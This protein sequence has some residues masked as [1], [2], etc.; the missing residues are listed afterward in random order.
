MFMFQIEIILFIFTVFSA[1]PPGSVPFVPL[2]YTLIDHKQF[3]K[4]IEKENIMEMLEFLKNY[5]ESAWPYVDSNLDRTDWIVEDQPY[6]HVQV[7]IDRLLC[8][9]KLYDLFVGS[10]QECLSLFQFITC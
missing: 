2:N 3:F 9:I 8:C 5:D 4:R 1:E 7:H 10:L 6:T